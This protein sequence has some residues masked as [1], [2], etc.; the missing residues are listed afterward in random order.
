MPPKFM[1]NNPIKT[2]KLGSIVRTRAGLSSRDIQNNALNDD[3]VPLKMITP[4]SLTNPFLSLIDGEKINLPATS[5]TTR[6]LLEQNDIVTSAR[7]VF[8]VSVLEKSPKVMSDGFDLVAGPLCMVVRI[9]D[10]MRNEISAAY[11]AWVLSTP[12]ISSKITSSARGSAAAIFSQDSIASLEVPFPPFEEQ[13]KIAQVARHA[14]QLYDARRAEASLEYSVSM[15]EL[16]QI[17]GLR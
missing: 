1:L 3:G 4:S 12:A 7:G 8:R 2:L 13:L 5:T 15:E 16:N 11:L 9:N 10:D 17:V 14:A 6:H